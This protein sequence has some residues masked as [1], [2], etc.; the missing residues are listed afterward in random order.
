ML[1]PWEFQIT[2]DLKDH[3]A[4]YLQIA[5]TVIEA[6][7]QGKLQTGDTLPGSRKLAEQ[8]QVNRNTVIKALDVLLAEGWLETAERKGVF[9]AEIGK[10]YKDGKKVHLPT[11]QVQ[12]ETLS[13]KPKIIFNDGIPDSRTA[14]I[15]ELARAYRQI[16][17]RKARWQMMG[18]SSA[19]GDLAFR[20]AIVKMLNHKRGMGL[21]TEHICVT[22]GS[23]MALY[24]TACCLLGKGDTVV[25]E[26]P[27]YKPAWK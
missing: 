3:K 11:S 16:F 19:Q 22:R 13:Q 5:D 25:V 9:V 6:I 21:T 26:N 7:K 24:L 10:Q 18:Y 17:N 2:I 14:P 27:G 12:P 23:Q 20:N 15:K 1:R 8:I 4:V